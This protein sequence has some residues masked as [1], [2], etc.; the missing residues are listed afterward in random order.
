V[1]AFVTGGSGFMGRELIRA[2]AGHEVRALARSDKSAAAVTAAGAAPVS[3]DLD[4]VEAMQLGMQGCDV[5]FHAA[6]HTAEWDTDEAFFRIN[7]LGTDN[8]IAAAKAAKVRRLV[9]V[10]S[11]AALADGRPL[12]RVDETRPLPERALP[13][14]PMTKNLAERHAR[15]AT[16]IEVVVL[17]PR[18]I[19]GRGDTSVL[20]KLVEAARSGRFKWI[21]GGHYLTSTCHVANACEG[22]MLAGERGRPGEVYFLTDGEPVELR[23]FFEQLFRTQGVEPPTGSVPRPLA[24][25]AAA[26]AEPIWRTLR[27]RS[28]PPAPRAALALLG[29]EMTV[30]DAKARRELG[31]VGRK[32][33]AEGLAELRG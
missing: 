18:F 3:G 13:G 9:H 14:Y 32:S 19:W 4:Q 5:V 25:L 33:I 10:S 30:V 1:R 7:V 27:L 28:S 22:A 8:V 26:V 31:Y 29:H 11:E 24:S 6:A 16:G 2:L 21:S 23:G 15:A 17:R 20:P 12:V